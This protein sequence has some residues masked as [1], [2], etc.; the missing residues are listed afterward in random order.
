MKRPPASLLVLLSII[1][2]TVACHRS[3]TAVEIGTLAAPPEFDIPTAM[4]ALFGNYD[5]S[6]RV[7][8]YDVP[9]TTVIDLYG[10]SFELG[11]DIDVRPFWISSI[12]EDHTRKAV[13]LTYAV[14]SAKD[15]PPAFD[16][17]EPFS[18]HA[19]APLIGAAIF[20]KSA[21]GWEVDSS[22]AVATRAGGWGR[23]PEAIR[24]VRIGPQRLGVEIRDADTG[25]GETTSSTTLLVPWKGKINEALVRSIA[26]DDKGMCG[27]ESLPCYSNRK[28]MN[29]VSGKDPEY[30]DIV[31]TLS[32][33]DL[34][35]SD[36]ITRKDV[37]G[38]ER[39]E[40]A[41]GFYRTE[42]KQGDTTSVERAIQEISHVR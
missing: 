7:S 37:R 24:I 34:S 8:F 19:C 15:H 31:L 32:G 16:G 2:C 4:A 29:F 17:D 30:Y 12:Q 25:Q 38:T 10:S 20:V 21:N 11:D 5:A 33:T 18:C 35:D 28:R 3:R 40:F 13:L 6:R 26:D 1:A 41:S 42:F 14:P 39:L 36:P 22:R 9:Q 23:P 27:K